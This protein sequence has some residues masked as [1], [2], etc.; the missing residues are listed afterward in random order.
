MSIIKRSLV[1]GLSA[2]LVLALAACG[3]DASSDSG[4]GDGDAL[5]LVLGHEGSE[6]DPRQ[7]AALRLK[8]LVEE[9][10]EGR[11]EIDIHAN[12]TLGNW[13]PMIEGL[14]LRSTDT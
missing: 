4:D 13:E 14:R 11:V 5:T 7:T 10:T 2:T 9:S 6:D 1:G 3:G 8:E 12:A